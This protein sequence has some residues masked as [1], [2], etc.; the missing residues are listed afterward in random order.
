MSWWSRIWHR[1]RLEQQLH[2]ELQFHVDQYTADLIDHGLDPTE[3]ERRAR[4]ELGGVEQIKELCRDARGTRWFDDLVLDVRYT[5][6]SLRKRAGF[7][8]VA[9]GTLALG[10]GAATVMFT[11]VNGVLLKPLAYPDPSRLVA[12]QEQTTFSTQ[13]GNIWAFAYPNYL[14]C[15]RDVRA[16]AL[17]AWRFGGGIVSGTGD[18]EYAPGFQISSNL[19]AVLGV[20]LDRG[21]AFLDEEDR[22]GGA[23]VA[24]ISHRLWQRRYGAH[25]G[26]IGERLV[27]D[28]TSY[29]IVGVT[30]DGFQLSGDGDVFTPLGQA[31]PAQLR[32]R[33]LHPGIRVWGRLQPDASL[34]DAQAQLTV[35][36]R[37]LAEQYRD[38]NESRTFV[39]SALRPNV[40][41]VRSTLWLL[42]GA[43]FLVLLIACANVASLLLARAVAR[44]RELT[45]RAALGAGRG[46]LFRQCLTESAVLAVIGGALGVVLAAVGLQPFIA[47]WPGELPRVEQVQ[48]DWYVLL[49][50]LVLSLAS[51]VL[52]GLAPA[53]RAPAR[54][55]EHVLRSSGRTVRGSSRALHNTFVMSEV[56]L[57]IV[58]LVCAGALGR[59][60]I[61]LSSLDPGVDRQ[62]VLVTRMALSPATLTNPARTRATWNEVLEQARHVPGVQAATIVDTVPMR[63]GNNQLEYSTSE[64][65]PP[66][67]QRPI[68]LATSVSADYATVMGLSLRSGRFFE[69]RDGPASVPVVV[70][71]DVLARTA[72]AGANPVGRKLWIR[73]LGDGPFEIIGIVGHVRHWGLASDDQSTVRAQIYYPFAQLPDRFV[74]RWSELMSIAVRTSLPP[75]SVVDTLRHEL[76]GST[77]DQVLYEVRTLDQ[78]AS[79]SLA[80]ARFLL[81]LFGVFA[82]VAL[83]LACIGIYGV[84]SFLTNERVPEIGARMAMGANAGQVLRLVVGQ[85]LRVI[86]AGLAAGTLAA[87]AAGRLL[88]QQVDGVRATEPSTLGAMIAVLVGAAALATYIPARRASRLDVMTALRQD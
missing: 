86:A 78:L 77:G 76:R 70:I 58:L 45:L 24:I 64:D 57:A 50:A 14:D 88:E 65:L 21:R 80:R 46:R 41:N 55:L 67:T 52:F 63:E 10:V 84:L 17:T 29:S 7:A 9:I 69:E 19:F 40:G 56:A 2:K 32:N 60:L 28:G 20:R 59:T 43:V 37:R 34:S 75:L 39:A 33:G 3:A 31:P 71:D 36:G 48:L 79:N 49:F 23:P 72:F 16:L 26:I 30:P 74:R 81:M 42:F 27:L 38:S 13:F 5:L 73:N 87:L 8:A 44:H 25:A 83:V 53:L 12:L 82:G 51:S 85:G 11:V 66:P 47:L 15:R 54:E 61:R 4:L 6:R 68:A 35:V 62:N 1:R 18:P 22:P